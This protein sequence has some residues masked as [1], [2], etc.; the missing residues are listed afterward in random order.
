M[1]LFHFS[2]DSGADQFDRAPNGLAGVSLISHLGGHPLLFRHLR[3]ETRF[4]DGMGHGLLNVDMLAHA[5]GRDSRVTM[6]VIRRG[7]TGRIEMFP[8]L[9]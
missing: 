5:H 6:Q 2:N 8:F 3:H 1:H 4:P 7:D 9:F